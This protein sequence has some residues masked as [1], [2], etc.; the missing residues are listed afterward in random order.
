[1]ATNNANNKSDHSTGAA[2]ANH[3]V[4]QAANPQDQATANSTTT[5]HP[6]QGP[7][8]QATPIITSQEVG[9]LARPQPT[10]ASAA[11]HPAAEAATADW[12]R[13]EVLADAASQQPYMPEPRH[14]AL[15]M[16]A[17]AARMVLGEDAQQGSEDAMGPVTAAAVAEEG[18]GD[19]A[20]ESTEPGAQGDPEAEDR[21]EHEEEEEEEAV[22]GLSLAEL[23]R[24]RRARLLARRVREAEIARRRSWPQEA[25]GSG[26]W[27]SWRRRG[28]NGFG[29]A[30]GKY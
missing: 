3:P 14:E 12:T 18:D 25:M 5:T 4:V 27:A 17:R 16:L 26:N 6:Q 8:T 19:V 22:G 28:G 23:R 20:A 15:I 2:P 11:N 1:M 29:P 7:A 30:G 24:R 13:L 9:G 10:T 21:R